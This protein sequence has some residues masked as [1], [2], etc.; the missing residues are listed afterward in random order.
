MVCERCPEQG[1]SGPWGDPEG[2]M[3]GILSLQHYGVG[4]TGILS[5]AVLQLFFLKQVTQFILIGL[6][7]GEQHGSYCQYRLCGIPYIDS[8]NSVVLIDYQP[9]FCFSTLFESVIWV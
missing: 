5:N 8:H 6:T 3:S 1:C 9:A 2:L 4:V 7:G